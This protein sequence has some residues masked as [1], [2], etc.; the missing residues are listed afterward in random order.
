ML[1]HT[2]NWV[3]GEVTQGWVMLIGGIVMAIA[4]YYCWKADSAIIRGMLI[5]LILVML[6]FMGY[7]SSLIWGRPGKA[8][9]LTTAY[10][11]NERMT[12]QEEIQRLTKEGGTYSMT[13]KGWV[14]TIIVGIALYFLLSAGYY[15]GLGMGIAFLGLMALITD[16]FLS[17]RAANY[18]ELIQNL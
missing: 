10:Q 17:K 5:P 16:L 1:E 3:K 4:C 8:K 18:L 6:I 11:Q 13:I 12:V 7:G 9:A 2:N 15:K 14:V